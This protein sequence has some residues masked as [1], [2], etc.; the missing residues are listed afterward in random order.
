MLRRTVPGAGGTGTQSV[1]RVVSARQSALLARNVPLVVAKTVV[2]YVF[3][4][5]R[6]GTL[7][8]WISPGYPAA[9]NRSK[10]SEIPTKMRISLAMNERK[11]GEQRRRRRNVLWH[12]LRATPSAQTGFTERLAHTSITMTSCKRSSALTTRSAPRSA[13]VQADQLA[14]KVR[15]GRPRVDLWLLDSS[16]TTVT[17]LCSFRE[18]ARSVVFLSVPR[19]YFGWQKESTGHCPTPGNAL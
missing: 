4:K 13:P 5:L 17:A 16:D 3:S 19:R 9:L 7:R 10:R 12:G 11:V 8:V 15:P 2:A 14:P 6:P 18:R 1:S